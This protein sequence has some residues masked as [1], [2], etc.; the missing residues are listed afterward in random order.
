MILTIFKI[1]LTNI[2]KN[3]IR[4]NYDNFGYRYPMSL[5]IIHKSQQEA[6][7]QENV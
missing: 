4:V 6:G 5:Q 2:T 1:L 3:V 7:C